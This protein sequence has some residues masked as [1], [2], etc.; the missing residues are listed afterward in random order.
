MCV[1]GVG[2]EALLALA[3]IP[4]VAATAMTMFASL[5]VGFW[6]AVKNEAIAVAAAGVRECDEREVVG[7]KLVEREWSGSER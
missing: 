5:A 3:R 4:R 6:R 7:F 1:R 2:E